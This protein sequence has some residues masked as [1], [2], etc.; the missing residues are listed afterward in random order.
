[1]KQN[2]SIASKRTGVP[3]RVKRQFMV[4]VKGDQSVSITAL[5]GAMASFC[6]LGDPPTQRFHPGGGAQDRL[7]MKGQHAL[8]EQRHRH[9]PRIGAGVGVDG[10][11]FDPRAAVPLGRRSRRD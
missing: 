2:G 9:P 11:G 5:R 6:R 7:D 4:K 8:A 1:M 10:H 3:G